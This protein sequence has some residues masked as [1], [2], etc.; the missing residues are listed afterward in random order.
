ML[1][2]VDFPS[3]INPEIIP[4]LPFRWYGLMYLVAF[5]I[6]Y[7]LF[8]KQVKERN[9]PMDD[10]GISGLF[11]WG[12]LGLL[13][14]ARIFSTIVYEPTDIYRLQPWL[15]FWP[16]RD[17]QFVGLQGMSY[18]GGVIGCLIAVIIYCARKKYDMR[19]I[20]DMVVTGVPLGFTFGR[21]G[22]FINGELYGRV[23]AGPF[24]MIFPHAKPYSA[25]LDWVRDIAAK[26]G[27]EITNPNAL[28]NLPRHPS[29]L[30]EALF[31][32]VILWF[33][34]WALRNRKP[35]RGFMM[36]MY[37]IG[38]GLFR[39]IIEYFREPD[40]GL[41]YR[42]ELVKNGIPPA[43]FSSLFNFSTGQV[44][45]FLMILGGGIWLIVASRL[46]DSKPLVFDPDTQSAKDREEREESRKTRRKLRK[47]LK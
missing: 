34:L 44:L 41:G 35:F 2:A 20:G 16:F 33:I 24:G 21:L 28:I 15:V 32:G 27:I 36:G 25:S 19:E 47:K 4:G 26:A 7:V 13:L 38:Y 6:A 29:Q 11:F 14:G 31:E 18:H 22:N 12:I 1:L 30:Y 43:L 23:T 45:C 17:G 3:W 5:A 40:E 37:L 42:I 9:F 46:P 10:D 39:F 8:R